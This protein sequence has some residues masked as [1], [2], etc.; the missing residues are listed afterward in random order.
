MEE[1][2]KRRIHRNAIVSGPHS[3]RTQLC[4]VAIVLA[5]MTVGLL[6]VGQDAALA[7]TGARQFQV[8]IHRPLSSLG[9]ASVYT[10]CLTSYDW[11]TG[12]SVDGLVRQRSCN[13]DVPMGYVCLRSTYGSYWNSALG[14]HEDWLNFSVGYIL[15]IVGLSFT[16]KDCVYLRID[17]KPN[18]E[19]LPPQAF[20]V[21][22]L[23]VGTTC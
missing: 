5:S 17:T 16:S 1:E 7:G 11:W 13:I 19:L 10:V 15:P 2:M 3:R 4:A 6:A 23:S 22:N 8:C 20:I 14:A 18:G 21:K 9:V 12:T